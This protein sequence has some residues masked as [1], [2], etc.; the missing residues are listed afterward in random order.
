MDNFS[1]DLHFFETIIGVLFGI[2]LSVCAI[3][4]GIKSLIKLNKSKKADFMGSAAN[5]DEQTKKPTFSDIIITTILL[6]GVFVFGIYIIAGNINYSLNPRTYS[7]ELD[8]ITHSIMHYAPFCFF[9]ISAIIMIITGIY[10]HFKMAK[11]Q[12]LIPESQLQDFFNKKK[13]NQIMTVLGAVI[14]F[15][16]I[17]IF[18]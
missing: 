4:Q 6:W 2:L 14:L 11:Q 13:N 16:I 18:I 1:D 8:K 15:V 12:A 7:E 3:V 9:S 5:S 10:R 17:L